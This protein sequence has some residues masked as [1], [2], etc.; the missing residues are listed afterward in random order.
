MVISTFFAA[1]SQKKGQQHDD[2]EIA[3]RKIVVDGNIKD[4]QSISPIKVE[5]RGHLWIGQGLTEAQWEGNDDLSF[6][7]RAAHHDEKLF[8][9]FEVKDDTLSNFDQQYAWLNDCIEIYVDPESSG[10][11]RITGIGAD[12][13]FE[14]RIGK[15]MRG[16]EMQ[17]LP[18]RPPKVF[19]DDSKGVYYTN[20]EQNSAFKEQWHG[21]VVTKKTEKG[22]LME[23]AFAVPGSDFQSGQELGLD[24]AVCDDDGKG[25]KSLLLW[26]GDKGEF[27]VTMDNFKKMALK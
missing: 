17:F 11:S 1:C 15:Q 3:D 19:V 2:Y 23:I 4:W 10:G 22:Y 14:D 13:T 25:R 8:F 7:W 6:N 16:Y 20:A 24:V 26:S 12:N 9:L 18:S 21:E 5:G 27:W